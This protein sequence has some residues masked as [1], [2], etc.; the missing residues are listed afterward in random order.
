M[1]DSENVQKHKIRLFQNVGPPLILQKT[2]RSNSLHIHIKRTLVISLLSKCGHNY[3]WK[4]SV[5]S[6]FAVFT[7][8]SFLLVLGKGEIVFD[9]DAA[10]AV[11]YRGPRTCDGRRTMCNP[12]FVSSTDDFRDP[13]CMRC[14]VR[15]T[16]GQVSSHI[17]Q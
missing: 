17:A 13:P 7:G 5:R 10:P 6:V 12:T 11:R 8:L 3:I 4:Q 15:S 14:R 9:R 2:V 16:A 1:I